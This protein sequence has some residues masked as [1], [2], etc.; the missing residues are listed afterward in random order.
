MSSSLSADRL[1]QLVLARLAASPAPGPADLLRAVRRFWPALSADDVAGALRR[2]EGAGSI[3]QRKVTENGAGAAR[4]LVAAGASWK[5]VADVVL[6]IHTMG[7]VPDDRRI[8]NRLDGREA[9]AAAIVG[10]DFGLVAAGEPP[11]TPSFVGTTIVWRMLGLKGPLPRQLPTAIPAR[12]IGELLGAEVTD[13]RRGLVQLA[14]R[15]VG[16]PRADVKLLRDGVVQAWLGGRSWAEASQQLSSIV[17]RD[18]PG[19]A[20]GD[21]VRDAAPEPAPPTA[22]DLDGTHLGG[23]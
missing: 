23:S 19:E 10:R 17:A 4:Q 21:T 22:N 1:D 13:W 20:P 3:A 12:I 18:A 6:P 5:T 9:W 7:W 2:L 15:S 16:A 8:L 11:P 14:A